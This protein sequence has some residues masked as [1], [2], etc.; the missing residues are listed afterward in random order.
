M[1]LTALRGA[2]GFLTRLPIRH[3]QSAWIAFRRTPLTFPLT[4]YIIG[5]LLALPFLLPLPDVTTA[6][7]VL[8]WLYAL[9]GIAHIDG[10]AD[11]GDALVA[12]GDPATLRRIMKDTTTGAG[13]ILAVL[14][15]LIGLALGASA[16]ATFPARAALIVLSAEVS[17]KLAM[18]IVVCLGS[19]THDGLGAE[20]AT[21]NASHDLIAPGVLAI[22]ATLVT[23]P[24]PA[25][26]STVLVSPLVALAISG[27]A[28]NALGGINGDVIGATNELT[29]VVAIHVGVLTWMLY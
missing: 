8:L 21:M 11:T 20:L 7:V 2:I 23:W 28:R 19:A 13:A 10:L 24:H 22:P 15:V 4:G 29:R 6:F 16:I 25:A 27:W 26:A 12:H 1:V 9:T 18:A 5:T 17:A 3:D 14:I